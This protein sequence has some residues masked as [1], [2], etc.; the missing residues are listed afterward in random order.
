MRTSLV[1]SLLRNASTNR[2]QRVDDVRLY[3]IARVYRPAP[4]GSEAP[5]AEEGELAGVLLGRRSPTA[6]A[7]G[8]DPVDFYD[9]KAAVAAVLEALGIEA[10]WRARGGAVAPPA[11][12]RRGARRRRRAPR[13]GRRAPS[14]RRRRRSSCRA[15]CSRSGSP[16]PRSSGA[17]GSCPGSTGIPRFPAVLRDLAVVVADEIEAGAVAGGA[18]ARSRS[19]RTRPCSTSTGA[20]PFRR[21]G[22]TS[23]SPSATAPPIGR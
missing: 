17:R 5:A 1:P 22:R 23:R 2:R 20:R 4:S 15:A 12:V 16:A 11:D 7:A 8:P 6:W 3:E 9:A 13:R 14:A 21:A 19:S 18:S 10:R